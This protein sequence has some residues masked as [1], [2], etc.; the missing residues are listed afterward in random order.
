[1]ELLDAIIEN[2]SISLS[3]FMIKYLEK[4][5]INGKNTRMPAMRE[6][7]FEEK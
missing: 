5:D 1:M 4:Y 2:K 3:R 6:R 7:L